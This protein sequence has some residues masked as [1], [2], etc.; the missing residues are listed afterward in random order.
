MFKIEEIG[1]VLMPNLKGK[2]IFGILESSGYGKA[3][4]ETSEER[5]LATANRV[6]DKERWGNTYTG[7]QFSP[8]WIDIVALSPARIA[9]LRRANLKTYKRTILHRLTSKAQDFNRFFHV[10]PPGFVYEDPKEAV[11]DIHWASLKCVDSETEKTLLDKH[12]NDL[13]DP[14]NDFHPLKVVGANF[15]SARYCLEG[16]KGQKKEVVFSAHRGWGGG[17]GSKPDVTPVENGYENFEYLPAFYFVETNPDSPLNELQDKFSQGLAAEEALKEK[18][19]DVEKFDRDREH[20]MERL[21]ESEAIKQFFGV[22][23]DKLVLVP[24]E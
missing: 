2:F 1:K 20:Q 19:E 12:W 22:V 10:P 8:R 15:S 21:K 23:D 6:V 17:M 11:N 4:L 18:I 9:G 16:K 14:V 3:I 13:I 7:H 24:E 5:Y